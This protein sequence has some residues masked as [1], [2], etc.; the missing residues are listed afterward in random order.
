M[1]A[2]TERQARLSG[3]LPVDLKPGKLALP[4]ESDLPVD[5]TPVE[6]AFPAESVPPAGSALLAEPEAPLESEPAAP[7][8]AVAE[9]LPG[10]S[11]QI[12]AAG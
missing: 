9:V 1:P 4:G 11:G 8:G 2:R 7:Q 10:R 3:E 12:P 6:Q 5:W